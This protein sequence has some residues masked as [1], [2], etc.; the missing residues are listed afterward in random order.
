MPVFIKDHFRVLY[1]HVPKTGGT[2][3]EFFFEKNGFSASFIDRG[4]PNTLAPVMKC[5]PQHMHA[6]MLQEVFA[7]RGFTYMFMTVRNP[8]DRLVSEY[9]MR[10]V[11][12]QHIEDI[13]SWVDYVLTTYP[14]NEFLIDNHIRPQHDF[15]LPGCEVFRQ[16]DGF[17]EAWVA[18]IVEK[19][20]CEFE[21]R[22]VEV[23]MRF[24][25]PPA[26]PL[27]PASVRRIREFYAKD[28]EFFR[29]KLPGES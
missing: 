7:L 24:A 12:Q 9:R 5:S 2:A 4:G 10:A 18:R 14:G 8:L 16:E 27:S 19:V 25:V 21:H 26:A 6:A 22:Q 1:V 20:G 13:D 15:W 11:M 3:V 28:F 29:Y 17:G 23:A